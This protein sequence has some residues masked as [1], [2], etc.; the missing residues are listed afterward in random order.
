M[1]LGL[2]AMSTMCAESPVLVGMATSS[3]CQEVLGGGNWFFG[4]GNSCAK[5][6]ER[7]RAMQAIIYLFR[8]LRFEASNGLFKAKYFLYLSITPC[9][10]VEVRKK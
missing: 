2:V 4:D 8:K 6:W 9:A 7:T 3:E 5:G 1:L 10:S